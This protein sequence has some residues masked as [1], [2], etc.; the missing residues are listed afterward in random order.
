[1]IPEGWIRL[2]NRQG[3]D[4]INARNCSYHPNKFGIVAVPA[5][6]V[7]PL[8][9]VGGFHVASPDDTGTVYAE[10]IDVHEVAWSL[11]PGRVRDTLLMLCENTNSLNFVADRARATVTI[12]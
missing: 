12:R 9:A 10:L 11:R 1:M 2:R 4:E 3:C 7:P 5:E 6:D 8:L